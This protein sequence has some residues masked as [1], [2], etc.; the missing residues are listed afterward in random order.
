[1]R[2]QRFEYAGIPVVVTYHPGLFVTCNL[3]AGQV[4]KAGRLLFARKLMSEQIAPQLPF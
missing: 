3:K 4:S 1:M 2:G